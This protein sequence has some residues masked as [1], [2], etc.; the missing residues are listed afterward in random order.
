MEVKNI[1][2]FNWPAAMR[3]MRNPMNSWDKNDTDM[4]VLSGKPVL[5]PNDLDL[6]KRLYAAGPEHR[7][8]MRQVFVSMDITA[9]L[10]W[11]KE[12]DQYR[13]CCTTNSTSTM[14]KLASTPIT[15][16]CFETDDIVDDITFNGCTPVSVIWEDLIN[17]CEALRQRYNETKDIR[18]WKELIRL[19]P[20]SWLQT[21]TWTGNYE[22]L[23]NIY[24][25]RKN[26]RLTEWHTFLDAIVKELP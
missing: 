2:T 3:G 18:Y 20:E 22:I 24:H 7:K 16:N 13:I 12:M 21:R 15:I 19:L 26:H 4:M 9:Q 25:Q 14:H 17:A 23:R 6:A 10:F 11:W 5:G 8:W 1:E